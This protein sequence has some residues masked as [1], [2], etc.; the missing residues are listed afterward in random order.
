[1]NEMQ[2][3]SQ[4]VAA[5]EINQQIATAKAYPR[6][7]LKNISRA[8]EMATSSQEIAEACMFSMPRAGNHIVGASIRFAE[9]LVSQW[10]NCRVGG[11][12]A[13]VSNDTVTAQGVFHDLESNVAITKES[14]RRIVDK[15]GRRFN[16]DMIAVTANAAISIAI[17]NAV[18]TGIPGA[19]WEG[20]FESVKQTAVGKAT[21]RKEQRTNAIAYMGKLGVT[22]GMILSALG[23]NSIDDITP[24][25]I[26]VL[27]GLAS[28]VRAGEPVDTV[29]VAATS[30]GGAS[31]VAETLREKAPAATTQAHETEAP[32][33]PQRVGD[34]WVDSAGVAWSQ[35]FH[36]VARDGTPATKTDGTFRMKRGHDEVAYKEYLKGE[37]EPE[38]QPTIAAD[39]PLAQVAAEA[40]KEYLASNEE[41][42]E[43]KA[44][45]AE[46]QIELNGTDYAGFYAA[47]SRVSTQDQLD[48]VEAALVDFSG[49][50]QELTKIE[51]FIGIRRESLARAP[52]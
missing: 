33:W 49:S 41:E 5:A 12:V 28:R 30:E 3:M 24:D 26:V 8:A 14:R 25:D 15:Y 7:S 10:G 39:E 27:R 50:D 52:F 31:K 13:D 21:S 17:R 51:G 20:V 19:L 32:E 35:D 37:P 11:R 22:T 18:L 45:P 4:L 23:R 34:G 43:P 36:A 40:Y 44:E 9:I 46:P 2:P 29:F 16:D 38:V 42:P 1:M 48:Q 6:D 47:L